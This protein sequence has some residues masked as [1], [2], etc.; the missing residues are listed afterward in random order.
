MYCQNCIAFNDAGAYRFVYRKASKD[1]MLDAVMEC[2]SQNELNDARVLTRALPEC[3][4][5][6]I[7]MLERAVIIARSSADRLDD[8][9]CCALISELIDCIE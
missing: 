9:Q 1:Q 2:L 4:E 3:D 6:T 7:L 8:K 5:Q